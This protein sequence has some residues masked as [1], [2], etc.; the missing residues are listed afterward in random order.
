MTVH[1][2]DSPR[3]FVS[4]GGQHGLRNEQAARCVNTDTALTITAS[5]SS[6]CMAHAALNAP[7]DSAQATPKFDGI[8]ARDEFLRKE[9]ERGSR[10]LLHAM[11]RELQAM[12]RLA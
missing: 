8:S 9:A 5:W 4:E 10:E 12:G 11:I 7:F 3:L 1:N 6:D 2:F